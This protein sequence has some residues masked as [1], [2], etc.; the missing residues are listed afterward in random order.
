[1]WVIVLS[2]AVFV[3][4]LSLHGSVARLDE[5]LLIKAMRVLQAV[6]EGHGLGEPITESEVS[7]RVSMDAHQRQRI[8]Q[9][10]GELRLIGIDVR[11]Q[12]ILGRDLQAVSLWQLYQ[13]LPDELTEAKLAEV[14]G[15]PRLIELLAA[16]R[17]SNVEH[18]SVS[19]EEVI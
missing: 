12:W 8:F 16:V 15:F 19:L 11:G 14:M 18:L 10:L 1:M 6:A 3:R 7:S 5:P 13:L 17:H 9:A 2:G 4:S